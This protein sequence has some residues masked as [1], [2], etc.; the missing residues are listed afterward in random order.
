MARFEP[1]E[2]EDMEEKE[3]RLRNVGRMSSYIQVGYVRI[4]RRFVSKKWLLKRYPKEKTNIRRRKGVYSVPADFR[5]SGFPT[6][7]IQRLQDLSSKN[8]A[9]ASNAYRGSSNN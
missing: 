5:V 9:M 2:K 3:C 8:F 6:F 7:N 4:E 1:P